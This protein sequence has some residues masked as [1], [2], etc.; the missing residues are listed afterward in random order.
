LP[1]VCVCGHRGCSPWP[2]WAQA[3]VGRR[4]WVGCILPDEP[5]PVAAAAAAAAAEQESCRLVRVG[6]VEQVVGVECWGGWGLCGLLRGGK[7]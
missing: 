1:I 3:E 4:P 5:S 6:G 2:L 7:P